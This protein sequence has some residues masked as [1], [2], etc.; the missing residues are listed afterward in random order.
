MLLIINQWSGGCHSGFSNT[1]L[2]SVA[3]QLGF[4]SVRILAVQATKEDRSLGVHTFPALDYGREFRSYTDRHQIDVVAA[5]RLRSIVEPLN[6][7]R[8]M[9]YVDYHFSPLIFHALSPLGVKFIYYSRCLL[10]PLRQIFREDAWGTADYAEKIETRIAAEENALNMS[11]TV[12]VNSVN[13][14]EILQGLY[15]REPATIVQPGIDLSFWSH[16]EPPPISTKAV[17]VGRLDIEKGI[18]R[19]VKA[20][21]EV[22]ISVIGAPLFSKCTDYGQRLASNLPR[23]VRLLGA[24]DRARVKSHMLSSTFCLLPSIYEPWGNVLAEAM[25]CGRVCI[26]QFDCGG[27]AEQIEHG[28][29]GFLTDFGTDSWIRTINE[30]LGDPQRILT[31]SHNAKRK[32]RLRSQEEFTR[33]LATFLR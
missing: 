6:C 28:V 15:N 24:G 12:L 3:R 9:L 18:H 10:R 13:Q 16:H 8:V 26:A 1:Q 4:E 29:D 25:A 22:D 19:L 23:N 32:A 20:P 33:N 27:A 2:L 7:T 31:V 5:E 14:G 17:V 30:L 11:S 21:P